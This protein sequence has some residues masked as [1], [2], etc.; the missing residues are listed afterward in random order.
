MFLNTKKKSFYLHKTVGVR[1]VKVDRT[2]QGQLLWVTSNSLFIVKTPLGLPGIQL[3]Q[4]MFRA[5][6]YQIVTNPALIF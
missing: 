5:M 6:W 3:P 1:A 4:K 2:E